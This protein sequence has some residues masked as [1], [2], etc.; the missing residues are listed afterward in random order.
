MISIKQFKG[1]LEDSFLLLFLLFEA[2]SNKL[3]ELQTAIMIY[4]EFIECLL[5]Y[6]TTHLFTV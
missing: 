3:T 1:L 4:I 2:K 5:S 6:L